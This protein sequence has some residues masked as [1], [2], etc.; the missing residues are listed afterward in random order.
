MIDT[1]K[2]VWYLIIT[3]MPQGFHMQL[4]LPSIVIFPGI[5]KSR[6]LQSPTS[7]RKEPVCQ[8]RIASENTMSFAFLCIALEI[9]DLWQQKKS[10]KNLLE[11]LVFFTQLDFRQTRREKLNC[12]SK[13]SVKKFKIGNLISEFLLPNERFCFQTRVLKETKGRCTRYPF[14]KAPIQWKDIFT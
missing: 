14:Q 6:S 8:I 7:H 9:Q 12:N 13:S 4:I 11:T 2:V 10:Q 1:D 3:S 5:L